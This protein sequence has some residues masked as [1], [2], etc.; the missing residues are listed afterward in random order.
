MEKKNCPNCGM[1]I[2]GEKCEYCGTV[3]IDW[4]IIDSDKPFYIKFR[5]DG[6]IT[7]AKCIVKSFDVNSH[8]EMCNVYADNK[9]YTRIPETSM[10]IDVSMDIIP[11]KI[12]GRET[13]LIK[14]DETQVD[15]NT[16]QDTL[17]EIIKGEH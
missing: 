11:E 17:N 12:F 6:M 15:P 10:S 9:I 7:R 8:S 1:P 4:A 2:T 3:F 5:H 13:L 16:I 14:I